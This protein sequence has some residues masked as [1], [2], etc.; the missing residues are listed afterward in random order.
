[1]RSL[2]NAK[3]PVFQRGVFERVPE[4]QRAGRVGEADA[5]VLVRDDVAA[6]TGEFGDD[7]ALCDA[8]VI[9]A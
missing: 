9:V 4:C 6:N 7:L 1:M 8:G 3:T 2:S 5:A